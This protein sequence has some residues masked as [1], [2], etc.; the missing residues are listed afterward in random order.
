[1]QAFVE[2]LEQAAEEEEPPVSPQDL[3]CGDILAREFQRFL[4]QR[5]RRPADPAR[6][7]CASAR[8]RPP[9]SRRFAAAQRRKTIADDALTD[10]RQAGSPPNTPGPRRCS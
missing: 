8:R 10:D 4:S 9:R 2:R 1:M 3:P 7:A 6:P 5:G